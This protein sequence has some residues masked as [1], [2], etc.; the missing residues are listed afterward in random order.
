MSLCL[1]WARPQN[2]NLSYIIPA[3]DIS[4]IFVIL[5]QMCVCV[6][7][8]YFQER[9]FLAKSLFDQPN[10]PFHH[11]FI[12][13]CSL[14]QFPPFFKEIKTSGRFKKVNNIDERAHSHRLV[15]IRHGRNPSN[16]LSSGTKR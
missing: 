9:Q 3:R 7:I 10:V 6:C 12:G 1:L 8:G 15:T 13:H 2:V 16:I 4:T 11:R 14:P 5:A